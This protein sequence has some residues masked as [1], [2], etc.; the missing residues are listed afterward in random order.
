[1]RFRLF[2][3]VQ[4]AYCAV[5]RSSSGFTSRWSIAVRQP[6]TT[7]PPLVVTRQRRSAGV[8][9]LPPQRPG[10]AIGVSSNAST[11]SSTVPRVARV[12]ITDPPVEARSCLTD[13]RV[14]SVNGPRAPAPGSVEDARF[15]PDGR[16][17]V[18]AGPKSARLWTAAGRPVRTCTARSRRS[19]Q[20]ASSRAHVPSCRWSPTASCAGGRASSAATSRRSRSSPSHV[21]APPE[22]RSRWTSG[23]AISAEAPWGG[24]ARQVSAPF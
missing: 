12:E 18:T 8:T 3:R 9:G 20:W 10:T 19:S 4:R 2:W 14:A 7:P 15:S 21:S 11:T 24:R 16:W 5:K 1:M 17:L 22:G 6:W 13:G 23:R